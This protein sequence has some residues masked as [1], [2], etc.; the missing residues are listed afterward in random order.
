[1]EMVDPRIDEYAIARTTAAHGEVASL[2]GEVDA[3][4]NPGLAGGVVEVKLLE[5]F[6]VATRARRILE[7]GTYTGDL[8]RAATGDAALIVPSPTFTASLTTRHETMA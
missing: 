3:M 4:R 6:V 5:A 2:R 1:M 8:L 7:I